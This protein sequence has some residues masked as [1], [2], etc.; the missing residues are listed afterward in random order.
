MIPQDWVI[1]WAKEQYDKKRN[2]QTGQDSEPKG[3]GK[4]KMRKMRVE[5][6]S[7]ML[8]YTQPKRKKHTVGT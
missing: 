2:E 4:G 8:S 6:K 5:R 3:K 1:Q 7:A